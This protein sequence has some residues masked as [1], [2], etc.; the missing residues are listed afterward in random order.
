LVIAAALEQRDLAAHLDRQAVFQR[1]ANPCRVLPEQRATHLGAA[2]LEGEVDMAGRRA[3]EVGDFAFDPD[4]AE[5]V[6]EQHPRA[7]VELADGQDLAVEA[8]S[9][10][11]I[12]NHG[13]QFKGI[14]QVNARSL[15]DQMI[16]E[17][18]NQRCWV[19]AVCQGDAAMAVG[20]CQ[21]QEM[22]VG[23]RNVLH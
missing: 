22:D 13:A 9:C 11:G 17:L 16:D 14:F 23:W 12:F 6:F 7:A 2:V 19:F 20:V 3:G 10:K 18:L 15:Y 4:I 8:E 5:H 21:W 1:L